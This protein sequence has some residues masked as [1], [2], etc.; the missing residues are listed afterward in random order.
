MFCKD[1]QRLKR[2]YVEARHVLEFVEEPY[3][4]RL[5]VVTEQGYQAVLDSYVNKMRSEWVGTEA[6]LL[7]IAHDDPKTAI[8]IKA[9]E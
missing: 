1:G 5:Q 9:H 3:M 8:P 6:Q 2:F 7:A 4:Q